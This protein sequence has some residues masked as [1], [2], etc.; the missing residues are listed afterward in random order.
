MTVLVLK[1]D[2][3]CQKCSARKKEVH[4][5]YGLPEG[6]TRWEFEGEFLNICPARLVTL[7]SLQLIDA[8]FFFNK[9][10]LPHEGGY[11][12]QTYPFVQAMRTIS[13]EMANDAEQ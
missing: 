6:D 2:L 8:Y 4:G 13:T 7:Q 3:D 11:L 5:Y 1:K 12:D 10:I 9:Q